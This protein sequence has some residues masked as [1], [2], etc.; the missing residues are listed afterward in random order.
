VCTLCLT[1]VMSEKTIT[2]T[3]LRR[4]LGAVLDDVFAGIT[5]HVTRQGRPLCTL[6]PPG[7]PKKGAESTGPTPSTTK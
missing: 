4:D 2:A 7:R 3:M 1:Q 6:V 5:V